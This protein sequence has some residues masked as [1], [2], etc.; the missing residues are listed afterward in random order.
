M[1]VMDRDKSSSA[2][3][4]T[5]IECPFIPL[6]AQ[7]EGSPLKRSRDLILFDESRSPVRLIQDESFEGF[8]GNSSIL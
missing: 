1:L 6:M 2:E 5:D 8:G 3:L 4:I 7:G